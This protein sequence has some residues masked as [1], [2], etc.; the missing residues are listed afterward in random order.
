MICEPWRHVTSCPV[1]CYT[2][3]IFQEDIN[4]EFV[5]MGAKTYAICANCSKDKVETQILIKVPT[6]LYHIIRKNLQQ[7][8]R[9]TDL[10][11]INFLRK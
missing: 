1:C 2:L 6:P 11:D 10:E 8:S 3:T 9:P 5:G 4:I 7:L